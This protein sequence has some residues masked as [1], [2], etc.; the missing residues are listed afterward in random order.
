[1]RIV[2][3]KA[4]ISNVSVRLVKHFV[5]ENRYDEDIYNQRDEDG[6]G[7]LYEK[8][9]V[10]F[11]NTLPIRTVNPSGLFIKCIRLQRNPICFQR[12]HVNTYLD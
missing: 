1:M 6:D 3:S 4:L 5:S 8:I 12:R 11:S 9:F 2:T 10:G 7:R